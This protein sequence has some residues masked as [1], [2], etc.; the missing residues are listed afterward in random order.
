M[1]SFSQWYNEEAD[2]PQLIDG[3]WV[4]LETGIPF[5]AWAKS[6]GRNENKVRQSISA[7]GQDY[8]KYTKALGG[9]ALTGTIKQKEWAGKIRFNILKQLPQESQEMLVTHEAFQS[10]K[11]W[12]EMRDISAQRLSD[13]AVKVFSATKALNTLTRKIEEA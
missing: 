6:Q 4:D 7:A 2:I 1:V 9:K 12:I 13:F 8:R 5:S 11:F 10:S 3:E